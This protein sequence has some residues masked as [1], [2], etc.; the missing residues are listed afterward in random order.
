M[1]EFVKR[2]KLDLQHFAEEGEEE[3]QKELGE[4]NEEEEEKELDGEGEGEEKEETKTFSE[5]DVAEIVAKKLKEIKEAEEKAKEKERQEKE[6]ED[7]ESE[8]DFEKLYST[9]KEE[10]EALKAQIV[11]ATRTSVL[12]GAGYGEEQAEFLV[13]MLKGEDVDEIK[14]EVEKLKTLFPVKSY[15]DPKALGNNGSKGGGA[16]PQAKGEE[17][18]RN[19]FARIM[20]K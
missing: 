14:G 1:T 4:D 16:N 15:V 2:L 12:T 17:V 9:L 10:N 5:E 13:E 6:K 7:A 20:G 11:K 19:M 3:E 8:G 18:G